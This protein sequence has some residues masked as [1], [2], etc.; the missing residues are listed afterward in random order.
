MA[1]RF[2]YMYPFDPLR[3]FNSNGLADP[4]FHFVERLRLALF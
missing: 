4:L 1:V 3:E 2:G